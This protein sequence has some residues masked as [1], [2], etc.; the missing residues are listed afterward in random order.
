MRT[1]FLTRAECNALRGVA[2]LGIVLHN[3]CHWLPGIVRENE[4]LFR[5][6]NASGLSGI[7]SSPDCRSTCCRSLATTACPCSSS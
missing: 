4:Y 3:Y 2:I 6:S 7:L 1:E 5:A